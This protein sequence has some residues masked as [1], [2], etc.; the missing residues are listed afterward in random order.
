MI[1]ASYSYSSHRADQSSLK[2]TFKIDFATIVANYTH[3]GVFFIF[4]RNLFNREA[5]N[6]NF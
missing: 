2:G 1:L 6:V 4:T 3:S 5:K